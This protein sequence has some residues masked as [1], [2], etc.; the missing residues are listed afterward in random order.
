[1]RANADWMVTPKTALG[2]ETYYE[3]RSV[4]AVG[5]SD[6]LVR[7]VAF[8]P[9]WAPTAKLN[10]SAR[11][12]RERLDYHGG[13][14]TFSVP[15]VTPP[16]LELVRLYRLGAYWEYTR[17]IHWQ[18]ALEHGERESNVLGRDYTYNAIIANVRYLF[19]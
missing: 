2:F 8:G 10:F 7:G 3:P 17:Q 11:V 13:S 1:W 5:V 4:I 9:G 14:F 19:W 12:M 6:A 15:G 18:F 16:T